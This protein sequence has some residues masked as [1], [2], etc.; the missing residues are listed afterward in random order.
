[1]PHAAQSGANSHFT[2]TLQ[3]THQAGSHEVLGTTVTVSGASKPVYKYSGPLT[4][5]KVIA[6]SY[7]A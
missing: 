4:S 3:Y 2:Y 7:H 6:I 1:V 5:D